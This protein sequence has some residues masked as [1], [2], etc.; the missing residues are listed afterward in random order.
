MTRESRK[1]MS[2]AISYIYTYGSSELPLLRLSKR[3]CFSSYTLC[4]KL[5]SDNDNNWLNLDI[6]YYVITSSLRW[7]EP[8]IQFVCSTHVCNSDYRQMYAL[9]TNNFTQYPNSLCE[10]GTVSSAY[11]DNFG[12]M[13]QREHTNW[14]KVF[15]GTRWIDTALESHIFDTIISVPCKMESY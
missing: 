13:S 12:R 11:V 2:P 7:N 8:H 14:I 5:I 15:L 1:K 3:V 10:V 4:V 9:V 6:V